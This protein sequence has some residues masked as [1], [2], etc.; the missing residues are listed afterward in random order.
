MPDTPASERRYAAIDVG[1][2]SVKMVVADLAA[3]PPARI[4]D[5]SM[6][7]RLGEGMQAQGN[8]L[9]EIPMRRTIEAIEHFERTAQEHHVL[10]I[11]VIGTAALRDALNADQFVQ[12]VQERC[13]LHVQAITGQEEARLSYLAVRQDS[14]WRE[15]GQL[16]VIDV[17]GGSTEIIVGRPHTAE[18]DSRRSVNLGAVRLTE[19]YLKGDP[20]T[21]KELAD[22]TQAAAKGFASFADSL[23]SLADYRVVGVGGTLTNL[24]AM[25][26]GERSLPESLHGHILTLDK[27]G[28]QIAELARKSVEERKSIPGLDPRRADIILGGAVLLMQALEHLGAPAIDIS[29]RG[30]RW[31][32]L[33]DRFLDSE[34]SKPR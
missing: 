23:G 12:R 5:E 28:I 11:A 4:Y 20:P 32:V 2:N 30:L 21:V 22:A 6:N 1:T 9:R 14:H 15:Y 8:N 19:T 31:G 26:R 10:D 25:D 24:G 13:G 3:N 34:T 29:T 18:I 17:G 27:L 33:Y 16:I 7:T